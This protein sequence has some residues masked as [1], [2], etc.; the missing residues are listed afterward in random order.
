MPRYQNVL[1]HCVTIESSPFEK[2]E[3][4]YSLKRK[5]CDGCSSWMAKTQYY[6][7]LPCNSSPDFNEGILYFFIYVRSRSIKAGSHVRLSDAS[8]SASARKRKDF[9]LLALALV[10]ASSRFTRTFSC[11][12][13]CVVW[14]SQ[15][16][17][18]I[19]FQSDDVTKMIFLKLWVLFDCS[20][21]PIWKKFTCKI[22]AL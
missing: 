20:E 2:M 10:L 17:S 13:A 8:I 4:G 19:E 3:A 18:W 5:F 16:H 9:L 22:L 12:Y 15:E 7:H 14:T 1:L 11:A 21:R 6:D